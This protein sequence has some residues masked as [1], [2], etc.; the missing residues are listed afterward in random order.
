MTMI[1]YIPRWVFSRF[2]KLKKAFGNK[3]FSF[4][5]ACDVLEATDHR[6]VNVILSE[7]RKNGWLKSEE[8]ST[9][10]RKTCY[11]LIELDENMLINMK[12]ERGGK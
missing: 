9:D 5:E 6:L 2:I 12:T 10:K 1:S 7:L 3:K 4:E 11:K 8:D